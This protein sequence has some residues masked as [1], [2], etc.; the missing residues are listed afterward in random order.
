MFRYCESIQGIDLSKLP[1]SGS[2]GA[3]AFADCVGLEEISLPSGINQINSQ[4]FYNCLNL[5]ILH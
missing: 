3:G 2:V 1:I 4:A 5:S